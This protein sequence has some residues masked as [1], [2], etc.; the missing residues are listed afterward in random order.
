MLMPQSVTVGPHDFRRR[1][2]FT[3]R[4]RGTEGPLSHLL[5]PSVT[6]TGP[7]SSRCYV[8]RRVGQQE[9]QFGVGRPDSEMSGVGS[10]SVKTAGSLAR[11]VP[12]GRVSRERVT[13]SG[14]DRR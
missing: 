13:M 2:F 14:V 3:V 11:P 1:A 5:L 10:V 12:S 9:H 4:D 6:A 7:C 8:Q